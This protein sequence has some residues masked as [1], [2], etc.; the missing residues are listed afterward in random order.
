VSAQRTGIS[1]R[2]HL[3]VVEVVVTHRVRTQLRIVALRCEDQ[4]SAATP[5]AHELRGQQLLFLGRSGVGTDVVTEQRHMLMQPS[6]R[7]IGPVAREHNWL[8]QIGYR[9][10]LIRVAE[11][12]LPR[13]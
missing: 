2:V 5:T 11:D 10:E 8:R 3:L 4:R 6:I 9:T 1:V 12:E 7:R 13:L